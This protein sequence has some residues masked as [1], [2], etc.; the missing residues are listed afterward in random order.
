MLEPSATIVVIGALYMIAMMWV[1]I[2]MRVR[3]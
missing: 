3:A 2:V 1:P